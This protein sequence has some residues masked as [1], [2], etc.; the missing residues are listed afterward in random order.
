MAGDLN[1]TPWGTSLQQ[2]LHES[3]L[4][5]TMVGFGVQPSFPVFIPKLHWWATP[6]IPIDQVLVSSQFETINR[7]LGKDTG[8]DHLPVVV[9][10]ALSNSKER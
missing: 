5:N 6:I 9:D 1:T 7:K 8:S 2:L 3:G 4:K 10:L